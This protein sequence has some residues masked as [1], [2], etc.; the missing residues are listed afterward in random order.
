MPQTDSP[1]W[2][3]IPVSDKSIEVLVI[4]LDESDEIVQSS[5]TILSDTEKKRACQFVFP[6]DQRRSIMARA[7]LRQLLAARLDVRPES[8]T[9]TYGAH[10]KPVLAGSSVGSNLHFNVSHCDDVAI[11]AFAHERQIGV[12]IEKVRVLQD[13][14]DVA[15]NF[16]SVNEN[17]A[18]N[19]LAP[20]DKPQ[21]FFNCWTRKEAFIKAIGEGLSHPLDHFDV[22]LVPGEPTRFLRIGSTPGASC[23][24]D[25]YSFE[26]LPGYVGAVVTQKNLEPGS[27]FK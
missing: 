19:N 7:R 1:D 20:H 25:I 26:P 27:K 8:I 14:D 23:A 10:G 22:S 12:D 13:A 9:F 3:E 24:W 11:Y 21:G 16:F 2:I 6:H 17:V 5:F 18:Y 15:N 4:R